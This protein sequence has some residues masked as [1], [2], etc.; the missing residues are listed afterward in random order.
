[1]PVFEDFDGVLA[2][3]HVES[4]PSFPKRTSPDG[5]P[6][7][8]M[9]VLD[10]TGYAQLGCYGSSIDTPNIDRLADGGL[11]Y[12][13]FHVTPLCSPTRAALLTGRNHH[14]VGMRSVANFNTGFPQMRGYVSPH[15][16]TMAASAKR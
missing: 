12:T 15:A 9:I 8:V 7:V 1:M 4:T 14:T 10:D 13:N 11:R 6:N 5:A 2:D 3:T 16:A